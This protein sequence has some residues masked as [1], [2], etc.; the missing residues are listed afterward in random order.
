MHINPPKPP[1]HIKK[2]HEGK[3]TDWSKANGFDSVQQAA[4]HV[5]ANRT[6]YSPEVVAMANFA[7]NFGGKG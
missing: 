3:F 7:H 2:S 6:K 4:T 1:I 5:M